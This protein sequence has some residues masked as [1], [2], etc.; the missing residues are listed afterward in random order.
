[1]TN[2]LFY[3]FNGNLITLKKQEQIKLWPEPKNQ[4]YQQISIIQRGL[5]FHCKQLGYLGF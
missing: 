5:L 4:T 1:M 3:Y 2:R